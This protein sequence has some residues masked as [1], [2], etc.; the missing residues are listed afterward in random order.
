MDFPQ[1]NMQD[2][3]FYGFLWPKHIT[4]SL[5]TFL[6]TQKEL[7]NWQWNSNNWHAVMNSRESLNNTFGT[8]YSNVEV[9]GRVKKLRSRYNVFSHMISS[10]GVVW[11]REQNYVYT[12]LA[13]WDSW[14]EV[15]PLTRA[16]R[17]VGE[18]LYNQLRELFAPTDDPGDD[19]LIIIV[20][21][22]DENIPLDNNKIVHAL[23]AANVV[24][25]LDDDI[26]VISSDEDEDFIDGVFDSNVDIDYDDLED[27]VLPDLSV[28]NVVSSIS[29][30]V[31]IVADTPSD[32]EV[33]SPNV[34]FPIPSASLAAIRES[35]RSIPQFVLRDEDTTSD[36]TE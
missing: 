5:V 2:E 17:S 10:S 16:Y 26:L 23:P 32:D 13:Q 33:E 30:D 22:D 29:N 8:D 9:L 1:H 18:P 21:S 3:Y 24:Q 11:N 31:I 25:P 36:E 6:L 14:R 34:D 12:S 15:Y 35:L 28:D 20:D 27:Y 7:G 4:E 19:E